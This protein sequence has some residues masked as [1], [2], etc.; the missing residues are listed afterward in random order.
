MVDGSR[1]MRVPMVI[2]LE[3]DAKETSAFNSSVD[4]RARRS[5]GLK[6]H[7]MCVRIQLQPSSCALRPAT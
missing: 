1:M 3:N 7:R 4:E 6:Y 2:Y 5:P